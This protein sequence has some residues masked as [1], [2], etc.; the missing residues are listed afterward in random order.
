V[1]SVEW[2][3]ALVPMV[4]FVGTLP[5]RGQ[6]SHAIYVAGRSGAHLEG[7]DPGSGASMGVGGSF[8]FAFT[9]HWS[10]EVE[11]WVP[12]YIDNVACAPFTPCGP[13]EFRDVIVAASALR[14][15]GSHAARPFML[16]GMATLW[17]HQKA[18]NADG[19][20]VEWTRRESAYPQVGVGIEIPVSERLSRAPEIRFDFL[21]LG[22]ILRPGVALVYRFH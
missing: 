1:R 16:L 14:R 21:F 3:T 17:Q 13:G 4:L 9:Q 19:S 2:I 12:G 5:V 8:A 11:G 10:V 6:E 7:T 15:F 20:P 18:T 22:G